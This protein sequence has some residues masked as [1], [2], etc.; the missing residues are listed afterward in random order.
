MEKVRLDVQVG[1][2]LPHFLFSPLLPLQLHEQLLYCSVGSAM[3]RACVRVTQC[4]PTVSWGGFKS[5]C[6]ER[7][8]M[9]GFDLSESLGESSCTTSYNLKL[10]V[11]HSKLKREGGTGA[12]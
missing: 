7:L 4:F 3:F 11:L 8:Q 2:R 9:D 6:L 5:A 12:A 10:L 1:L